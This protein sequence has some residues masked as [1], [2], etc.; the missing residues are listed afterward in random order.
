MIL[1]DTSVIIDF[2]K[3]PS[4]EAK[5]IFLT[6][7]VAI[8]GIVK[9]EL[10]HGAKSEKDIEAIN[11][12]LNGFHYVTIDDAVW[13]DLGNLLFQLRNKGITVPFQDALMVT[14]ARNG[15]LTIWTKD[16]H[17]KLIQEVFPDLKLL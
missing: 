8:C 7:G 5:N 6:E 4:V 13:N 1:V 15:G 17:F 16:N 2:W 12:A 9:A 14:V 10:I 11:K 3:N